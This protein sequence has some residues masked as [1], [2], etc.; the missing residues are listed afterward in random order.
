MEDVDLL[1]LNAFEEQVQKLG[2]VNSRGE[3]ATRLNYAS[4]MNK[5]KRFC[6][7]REYSE[8]PEERMKMATSIDVIVFLVYIIE[9]GRIGTPV[10]LKNYYTR[11][12]AIRHQKFSDAVPWT[13]TQRKSI[14]TYI[15]DIFAQ[16]Y[17]LS[18]LREPA[19]V[20]DFKDLCTIL[21]THWERLDLFFKNGCMRLQ[22]ALA[23][24]IH[25]YTATRPGAIL[26]GLPHVPDEE[27]EP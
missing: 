3:T 20:I 22:F 19:S 26:Y 11:F 12:S 16:K 4:V 17:R 6:K 13:K 15:F 25:A 24:L 14:T 7:Y 21:E 23:I 8:S 10:S 9:T 5:W 27:P 18:N 2:D 1:G